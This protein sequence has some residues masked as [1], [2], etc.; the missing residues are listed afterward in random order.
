[1]DNA[2]YHSKILNKAPTKCSRKDDMIQWLEDNNI[3]HD[4]NLPKAELLHVIS[5]NKER[6]IY[7]I[8]NIANNH[9]HKIARLP[10]YHCHLNPIEL[11][12]AQVKSDVRMNN[13]NGNQSLKRVEQ[14]TKEAIAKVTALNWRNCVNHTKKIEQEYIEKDRAVSHLYERFVINVESSSSDQEDVWGDSVC[15]CVCVFVCNF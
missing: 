13:S 14:L 12:W 11:I 2:S 15:V 7:A 8:D 4:P 5:Q 3:T 10:P 6:Q 1:M 9:G